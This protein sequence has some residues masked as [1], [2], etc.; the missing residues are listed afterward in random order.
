[1]AEPANFVGPGLLF[2]VY[3][4]SI[5]SHDDRCQGKEGSG[6]R[7]LSCLILLF[8]REIRDFP[9]PIEYTCT[10]G[11]AEHTCVWVNQKESLFGWHLSKV[12]GQSNKTLI[13]ELSLVKEKIAIIVFNWS[14]SFVHGQWTGML[15]E[16]LKLLCTQRL[17]ASFY[18]Q[19]VTVGTNNTEYLYCT[20]IYCNIIPYEQKEKIICFTADWKGC[21][22]WLSC[23]LYKEMP[24]FKKALERLC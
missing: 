11:R 7:I 1:M 23:K 15:W 6:N 8:S 20:S 3:R 12:K 16:K 10:L 4:V 17:V 13:C 19:S 14:I 24:Q 18:S 21:F 5:L 2:N 22:I 9:L